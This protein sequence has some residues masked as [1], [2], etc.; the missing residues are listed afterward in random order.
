MSS[1]W[2]EIVRDAGAGWRP[3]EIAWLVFCV[4]AVIGLSLGIGDTAV[5]IT[6][7]ATGMLYTV[8][9]G[10]GKALCFLFG[11]V[12]T[13]LY[14]GL[15][16]VQGYYG[17]CAL[18]AYYFLMMFPGL[19][20]WRRNRAATAAEG[21]VRTRLSGR[22]RVVWALACLT[23]TLAL[24]WGLRLCGGS[25]PFCD[26]L[27]NVLSV[28]AMALTVRRALEQWVLWIAVDAVE[29]FMWFEVWRTDGGHVSVLLMW[30]LFLANGVYMLHLWLSVR[31]SSAAG[32]P[33]T[34]SRKTTGRNALSDANLVG[35]D[36]PVAPQTP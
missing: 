19:A 31:Q 33:A 34:R 17:D 6:A 5:G 22:A 13:P 16:Y 7:A 20:A 11:L 27:T 14:A 8:L 25:R 30:L 35:R 36:V 10:K 32:S 15:S 26:A 4:A 23:G 1:G 9:A 2:F 28:A 24:G 12:N 21:I 29:V 3:G 18:N